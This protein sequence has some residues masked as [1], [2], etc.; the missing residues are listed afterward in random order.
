M[1]S[2]F[3]SKPLDSLQL[4]PVGSKNVASYLSSE[5]SRRELDGDIMDD[6]CSLNKPSL[7]EAGKAGP[8]ALERPA[9]IREVASPGTE[10]LRRLSMLVDAFGRLSGLHRQP[11]K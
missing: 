5:T 11:V 3:F 6:L 9:N 4:F 7:P 10:S 2:L 1:E 8:S